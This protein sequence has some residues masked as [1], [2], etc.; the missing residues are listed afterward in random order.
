LTAT[1]LTILHQDEH[2]VAVDKPAWWVVHRTR[3]AKGADV[4]LQTLRD[5]IG[6][7]IYPV[8]RLDRQASGV[9]VF[10]LT[11]EAASGLSKQLREG[12]IWRKRYLGLCRGVLTG[13]L[14]VEHPVPEDGVRRAA[15]TELEPL[16]VYCDRFTLV[17]AAPLT[18]RYHQIRYHLKHLSCPLV[19]DTNYGQG[20]INRFFRAEPFELRRLFLHAES[21]RLLHPVEDRYLEL[22]APLAPELTRTLELLEGFSNDEVP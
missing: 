22:S 11:H 2:L 5:Q 19:G 3:G 14:T 18:G 7:K 6:A 12:T 4:L 21:L 17:R 16:K 15:T 10:G 13:S 8:H 20:A 9:I 1:P